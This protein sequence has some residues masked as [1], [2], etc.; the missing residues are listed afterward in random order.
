MHFS[1]MS[2]ILCGWKIGNFNVLF[3]YLWIKTTVR[4]ATYGIDFK[5]SPNCIS[6][7]RI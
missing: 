3:T 6:G 2:V 5:N 1:V 4:G 7:T